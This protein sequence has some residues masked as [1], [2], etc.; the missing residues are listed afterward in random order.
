MKDTNQF[1][2]EILKEFM[3]L[4]SSNFV[5]FEHTEAEQ[6]LDAKAWLSEKLDLYAE[7]RVAEER[8]RVL[9][10]VYKILD[11]DYLKY[12]MVQNGR[13]DCKNCGLDLQEFK[14]SI[15]KQLT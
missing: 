1:K 6:V 8:K 2:E 14:A 11:E 5:V 10:I 9:E 7:Q 13:T 3:H 15:T 12:C 4:S